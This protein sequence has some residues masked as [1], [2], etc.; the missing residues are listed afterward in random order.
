MDQIG[1]NIQWW[2][3]AWRLYGECKE[4]ASPVCHSSR[5]SSHPPVRRCGAAPGPAVS[6][7]VALSRHLAVR[8]AAALQSLLHFRCMYPQC[9]T[10]RGVADGGGGARLAEHAAQR[11]HGGWAEA[12]VAGSHQGEAA[13]EVTCS[14]PE[15]DSGEVA[16]REEQR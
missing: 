4:T 16:Q 3:G 9:L 7:Q 1:S 11:E 2:P 5:C 13:A 10:A 15:L 6:P 12:A 8:R 14:H